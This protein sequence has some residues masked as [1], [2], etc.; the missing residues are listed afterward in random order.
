[1][2]NAVKTKLTKEQIIERIKRRVIRFNSEAY[3]IYVGDFSLYKKERYGFVNVYV[4]AN[5]SFTIGN[6]NIEEVFD[7]GIE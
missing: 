2:N 7:F 5:V 1:M 3:H 4:R 6:E